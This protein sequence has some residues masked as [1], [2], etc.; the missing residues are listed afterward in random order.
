MKANTK[1]KENRIRRLLAR[2]GYRL[3]KSRTDGIVR[4]N[5][6]FQGIN[7]DDYGGYQIVDASTNNVAAGEHF[8]MDLETVEQWAAEC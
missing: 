8:S 2:Q 3:Q 5:G 6:V 7:A 4:V 1:S